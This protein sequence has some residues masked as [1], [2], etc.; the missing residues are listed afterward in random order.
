MRDAILK[1]LLYLQ[2]TETYWRRISSLPPLSDEDES[3]GYYPLQMRLHF[4]RGHFPAFDEDGVPLYPAPDG[5]GYTY[6]ITTMASYALGLWE[7]MIQTTADNHDLAG[8]FL[9][10][11]NRLLACSVEE[12]PG[13]AFRNLNYRTGK[14]GNLSAMSLGMAASVM[15][16]AWH[17][18]GDITFKNSAT[19]V[20]GFF[21]R[22]IEDGGI[23]GRIGPEGLPWYE[24]YPVPPYNHVLNG[25]IFSLWGLE[26]IS[27]CTGSREAEKYFRTGVCSVHK[28]I[29]RFDTGYWSLYW[30][31]GRTAHPY[32]AS[33]MYHNLH[34]LQLE[35]LSEQTGEHG[36]MET[37]RRFRKY[38]AN[39][40]N[41]I[42]AVTAIATSKIRLKQ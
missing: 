35:I 42:R 19:D 14:R 21:N 22:D 25:K 16:R 33:M 10:V 15:L 39:P 18:T 5:S 30:I 37:A 29:D 9:A 36:V 11:V 17:L 34:I 40:L 12:S 4:H 3:P 23:V 8:H 38:A 1:S 7:Q 31:P 24:E 26:E 27:R 41:R 2:P 28:L 13:R 20:L 32:V 6:Y